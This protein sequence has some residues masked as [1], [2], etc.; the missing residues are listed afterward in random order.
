MTTTQNTITRIAALFTGMVRT[1]TGEYLARTSTV[2]L[3]TIDT[4]DNYTEVESIMLGDL[5]PM[6]DFPEDS[7][8]TTAE[9]DSVVDEINVRAE[10]LATSLGLTVT[11]Y[12]SGDDGTFFWTVS[13]SE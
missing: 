12:D 6:D 13:A 5:V 4:D 8:A 3:H 11:G 1:T 7:H 2:T 9:V 10:A